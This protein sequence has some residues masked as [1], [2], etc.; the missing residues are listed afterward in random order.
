MSKSSDKSTEKTAASK[1]L[2]VSPLTTSRKDLLKG[3][4][5]D[6][7]RDVIYRLVQSLGRLL[8]CREAFGRRLDLTS[9]QFTVLMGVAYRQ[10]HDGIAIA[11][12]SNYIGLAATHVTTEVGR[13][14]RKGLLTKKRN[15]KDKRSVLIKLSSK[16][17]AA[18]TEVAPVV[19]SINDILF[20]GMDRKQLESV[21]EFAT[22]LLQNSEYAL[23]EIKVVET[24]QS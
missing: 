22:Q 20:K 9:S 6:W 4:S 13:L 7:M 15:T 23:A 17:E 10:G 18:V 2:Y 8:A 12:L 24:Y 21:N 11:P 1:G 16:G 3:G 19:R 14:I 5:D